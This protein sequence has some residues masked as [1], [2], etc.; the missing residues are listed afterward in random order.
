MEPLITS[1]LT[2]ATIELV[3][4][5]R[6]LISE[7]YV[8]LVASGTVSLEHAIIGTPCVVMYKFSKLSYFIAAI[9]VLKKLKRKLLRIYGSA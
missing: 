5:S 8:S 4:D 7:S 3:H 1:H 6:Q 9:I 2:D